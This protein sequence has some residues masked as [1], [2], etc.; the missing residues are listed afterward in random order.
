MG[1]KPEY[2]TVSDDPE[3]QK[4]YEASRAAGESH[5]IALICAVRDPV[6]YHN[7][8]SPMNPRVNRGRGH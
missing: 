8:M 3:V 1:R 6:P 5:N 4:R 7:R 2:E